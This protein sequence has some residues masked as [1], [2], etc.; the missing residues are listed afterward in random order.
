MRLDEVV[1]IA[2]ASPSA[3]QR[4]AILLFVAVLVAAVTLYLLP[5]IVAAIRG[6]R[7]L[8][9]VAAVNI[10]LGWSLVGW[11]VAWALALRDRPTTP[12]RAALA[13]PAGWYPDPVV[14]SRLRYWTG[15]RWSDAMAQPISPR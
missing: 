9:S 6:A 4:G 12:Q 10:L 15:S 7:D 11:A 8:G 13:P 5:T 3:N 1:F 2:A 14:P